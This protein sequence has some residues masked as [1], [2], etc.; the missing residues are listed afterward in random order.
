MKIATYHARV[1]LRVGAAPLLD[2]VAPRPPADCPEVTV[3]TANMNTRYSLQLAL[4]SLVKHTAYPNY[5]LWIADNGSTDSSLEFLDSFQSPQ[6]VEITRSPAPVS[7]RTWLD[8]VASAVQTPYWVAVDSDMLFTGSDW[9]WD[10]VSRM[11]TDPSLYIL[12][13][14]PK[15]ACITVDPATTFPVEYAGAVSSWLFC[16]RTSLWGI[17]A[18]PT[19]EY[20]DRPPN[21]LDAPRKIYD[22]GAHLLEQMDQRRLRYASMPS[23]Y[24]RKFFHYRN[25]SWLD[26]KAT[27][28]H[29]RLKRH[30][31]ADVRRRARSLEAKC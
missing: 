9:L 31:V 13:G 11:E 16:M 26:S 14:E 30:Q 5:R 21:G 15:P 4:A 27:S 6:P 19:F 8:R 29:A 1:G 2:L 3:F 23:R 22:T 20:E 28:P 7:H 24:G 17:L 12:S 10:L 18:D 25:M